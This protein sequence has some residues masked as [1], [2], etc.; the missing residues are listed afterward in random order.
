VSGLFF[1]G[2]KDGSGEPLLSLTGSLQSATIDLS[3][4]EDDAVELPTSSIGASEMFNEP[5]A[6]S[7]NSTTGLANPGDTTLLIRSLTAL[8][9]GRVLAIGTVQMDVV[10]TEGT[11]DAFDI[12]IGLG[13]TTIPSEQNFGRLVMEAALRHLSEV[14]PAILDAASRAGR[15]DDMTAVVVRGRAARGW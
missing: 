8:A 5:G 4:V 6:A 1:D 2:N 14:P 3:M 10:H 11:N 13:G 15:A 9:I 7:V 12:G